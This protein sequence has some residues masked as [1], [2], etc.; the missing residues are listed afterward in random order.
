MGGMSGYQANGQG[1][2]K[3]DVIHNLSE[4]I[5]P[6][7]VHPRLPSRSSQSEG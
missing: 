2:T 1:K 7:L 6:I 4:A 5:D 3:P